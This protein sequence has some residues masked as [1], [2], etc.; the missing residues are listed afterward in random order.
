MKVTT[1]YCNTVTSIYSHGDPLYR[2]CWF[3][4]ETQTGSLNSTLDVSIV[5]QH[6]RKRDDANYNV[7]SQK[8]Q[9]TQ[10]QI[11]FD[12]PETCILA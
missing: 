1:Q 5:H 2:F 7:E 11:L 10:G 9:T 3:T 12:R 8:N 6:C 4:H